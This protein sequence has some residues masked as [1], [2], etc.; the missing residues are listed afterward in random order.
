MQQS[1]HW[2]RRKEITY[3]V[4]GRLFREGFPR[5]SQ[6]KKFYL[7]TRDGVHHQHCTLDR[8]TQYHAEGSQWRNAIGELIGS[9]SVIAWKEEEN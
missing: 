4:M 8:S 3:P 6:G 1:E 9:Y 2:D 7:I 5:D